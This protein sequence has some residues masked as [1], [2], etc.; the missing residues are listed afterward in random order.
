MI[1]FY[2]NNNSEPFILFRTKYEEALESDQEGINAISIS[3]LSVKKNEVDSRF[4]NLKFIDNEEFIFFS[5]YNSPKAEQFLSHNQI[6]AL[7]FWQKINTQIRM[8]ARIKKTSKGFNRRYFTDRSI[9]KNALS[10]S[11]YQSR[12]IKSFEEIEKK[13]NNALN[14]KDLQLCPD[15]WGGYCFVPYEIEFWTGNKFRLNKRNLYIKDN[16]S[17]NHCILEP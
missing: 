13:Y 4:V 15:Y 3:S 17:W 6:S 12:K 8:K 16:S 7:I 9:K 5:N 11:S 14:T 10:I 1:K 2:N